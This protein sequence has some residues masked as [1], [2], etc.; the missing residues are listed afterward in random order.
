MKIIMPTTSEDGPEQNDKLLACDKLTEKKKGSE[1]DGQQQESE[2]NHKK[3]Q[4]QLSTVSSPRR[5]FNR[6]ANMHQKY[7]NH[8]H[9]RSSYQQKRSNSDAKSMALKPTSSSGFNQNDYEKS[10]G[11]NQ[12]NQQQQ[13]PSDAQRRPIQ[14]TRS[15][16]KNGQNCHYESASS[17]PAHSPTSTSPGIVENGNGEIQLNS[18][19]A[20]DASNRKY[21]IDFLHSVGY[22][23]GNYQM[24]PH[25]MTKSVS[26]YDDNSTT[27]MAFSD[28]ASYYNQFYTSSVYGNPM[29]IQP[30]YQNSYSRTY[31]QQPQSHQQQQQPLQRMQQ[32]RGYQGR[33][34][35]Y[36]LYQQQQQQQQLMYD[37]DLSVCYHGSLNG[38]RNYQQSLYS[39]QTISPSYQNN[40]KREYHRDNNRRNRNFHNDRS[41]QQQ[42]GNESR[43]YY[44]PRGDYQR[45]DNN[46]GNNTAKVNQDDEFNKRLYVRANSDDQQYRS[47]S[48]TPPS[49]S[50]SSS[51]TQ[52]KAIEKNLDV[53]QLHFGSLDLASNASGS[54]SSL[55]NLK[56]SVSEP[57]IIVTPSEENSVKE[58]SVNVWINSN[59]SK[60]YNKLS[61]SAEQ[62]NAKP[63]TVVVKRPPSING[64]N[65][66]S[67]NQQQQ[68]QQSHQHHHTKNVPVQYDTRYPFE[69]F[70]SRAPKSEMRLRPESLRCG[71]AWDEVSDDMWHKFQAFQ[72]QTETYRSKIM[73][74]K[75]LYNVLIV[76]NSL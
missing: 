70:L 8:H 71:T 68:H 26:A 9:N 28:T 42:D 45:N 23:M 7:N 49:S 69:Y 47:L 48:P 50:K 62:L 16:T 56:A 15:I 6:P 5:K 2:N 73:L 72:Q 39:N 75:E 25:H 43:N 44:R 31:Q 18:A 13:K 40:R 24:V 33:S 58:K 76:R 55:D 30:Q 19:D 3:K 51:P 61:A 35:N 22:K 4:Q 64:T 29:I 46:N 34:D 59:F 10:A 65:K 52:E 32:Q 41:Y 66:K 63:P 57:I 20:N 21:S 38:Q 60:I 67:N 27:L 53:N 36:R 14:K 54:T 11:Q 12:A 17:S 37:Q 74:W 1:N